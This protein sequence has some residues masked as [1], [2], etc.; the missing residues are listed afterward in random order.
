MNN[1]LG[2]I[3]LKLINSAIKLLRVHTPCKND[4][5][6]CVINLELWVQF[7]R[8]NTYGFPFIFYHLFLSYDHQIPQCKQNDI[9]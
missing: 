3:L 8:S 2:V 1:T 4:V 5:F 7:I 6:I 9:K